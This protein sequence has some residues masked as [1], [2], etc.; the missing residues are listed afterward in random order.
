MDIIP[1][2]HIKWTQV[3]GEVK[4]NKCNERGRIPIEYR[5]VNPMG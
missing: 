5:L 1:V 3:K 4:L 2:I